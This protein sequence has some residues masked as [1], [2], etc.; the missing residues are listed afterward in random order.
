MVAKAPAGRDELTDAV[1]GVSRALVGIALRTVAEESS[2]ITLVQFRAL[3][4][5]A[6]HSSQPVRAL[7]AL[8]HVNPS[9]VTR[10]ASR[11]R[12]KG[13]LTSRS[14]PDDRRVTRLEITPA[15]EAIVNAVTARRQEIIG[16]IVQRIPE[17]QRAPVVDSLRAFTAAAGDGPDQDWTPG[18]TR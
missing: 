16:R 5:L 7:A 1:L 18:W 2:D 14:D 3:A 9:T 17:E 8:L 4:T 6:E 11:L 13:L 10:M 12:R 15:G